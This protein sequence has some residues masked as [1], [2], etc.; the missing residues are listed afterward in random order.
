MV[1][2]RFDNLYAV[3]R[4]ELTPIQ[5][6]Q[7]VRVNARDEVTKILACSVESIATTCE[8]LQGEGVVNGRTNVKILYLDQTG[9][10]C[11]ANCNADFTNTM[12]GEISP[13]C[14]MQAFVSVLESKSSAF[15]NV[16]S[17][18]V[19]LEICASVYAPQE[20]TAFVDGDMFIKREEREITSKV[21]S[22]SICGEIEQELQTAHNIKRV[23]L[24][25]SVVCVSDF[26]LNQGVATVQGKATVNVTYFSEKMCFESFTFDFSQDFDA[27]NLSDTAQNAIWTDVKNTK[28][29]L[30]VVEDEPNNV[31]TAEIVLCLNV[32][33]TQT[34]T[35]SVIQ[36]A[37]DKNCD[38]AF[39]TQRFDTVLPCGNSRVDKR[40]SALLPQQVEGDV[41]YASNKRAVVSSVESVDG[42]VKVEGVIYLDLLSSKDEDYVVTPIQM[43]FVQDLDVD[44]VS[45][46]CLAQVSACV[47]AVNVSSSNGLKVDVDLQ[48]C[49]VGQMVSQFAV[50]TNVEEIALQRNDSYAIEVSIANKGD[51]LWDLAKNLR[52]SQEEVLAINP[53]LAAPIEQTTKVVAY[54]KL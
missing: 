26:S 39:T 24:A 7:T 22:L 41:V 44:F 54:N 33:Q 51:T 16:I 4:V 3:K 21:D 12:Q 32:L 14:R 40:V 9:D 38:L 13:N 28:I 23:L 15:G 50:I 46:Q 30:D 48:F 29:R 2:A 34:Q 17:V 11:S 8:C 45:S 36:D 25:D 20:I 35:I 31:L 10:I 42:G 27:S 53:E 1:N 52:L 6:T 18:D 43:P 19:L 47:K 49:V 37:Y 5:V